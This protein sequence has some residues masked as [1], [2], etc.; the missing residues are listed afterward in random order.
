MVWIAIIHASDSTQQATTVHNT[1]V[2]IAL[3]CI[4]DGRTSVVLVSQVERLEV[5]LCNSEHLIFKV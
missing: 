1:D 3:Y 2:F 5:S 4:D